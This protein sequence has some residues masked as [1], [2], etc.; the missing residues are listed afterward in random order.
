VTNFHGTNL[1]SGQQKFWPYDFGF[2]P[3]E[4]ISVIYEHFLREEDQREGAFYTPRFLAEVVLDSALQDFH[5]LIGKKFLDPACGSGIFLVGLFNRIAEEWKQANPNAR[6]DR[7]A[8]ELMRLLRESLFGVDKNLTACRITAF[9]LYLAYL[10]HLTPSDIQRL[11]K[12]GGALPRLIADHASDNWIETHPPKY[13]VCCVDFFE[14]A[15]AIPD[16]MDLVIGNPPWGSKAADG[17]PANEWCARNT[18]P[19]PDKQ[20][21]VAFIWKSAEH[22]S[23]DGR[24]CLVLPHGTLFNHGKKAIEFQK[25]WVR[26][27]NIRRVLNLADLR[28]FLFKSAKHP[29]IVVEFRK[30]KIGA[31][32][33]NVK[34]WTPKAD[35]LIARAEVINISPVDRKE[36]SVIDLLADLDRPDAPQV[37]AQKF[38][39]SPRDL[40]L[41]DRLSLYPRLREHVRSSSERNSAKPWVIAEGFQPAGDNDDQK[42]AKEITLPSKMFIQA[43]SGAIDLIS[44][45]TDCDELN[46]STI[47]VRGKSNTNVEI[48]KAPHVLI[49]KGFKRITFADFDV[50]FRHSLRGIHGPRR[51]RDLLVFLTAFLQPPSAVFCFS[52]VC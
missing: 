12:K 22:T 42:K 7:R 10:D 21:A 32:N 47:T 33:G 51:D 20:I 23:T 24:V 49:T 35:W 36:I 15:G 9:A 16:K 46:S 41:I 31:E 1:R 50:S 28:Q 40:R 2:I 17:T 37:W 26:H 34:Y 48:Y 52:H 13:N 4:T 29:A 19:L 27:H 18:K 11:Q 3:I 38:W 14:Q 25:T 30:N 6:Y 43:K 44:H 8:E 5:T 45:P 39:G